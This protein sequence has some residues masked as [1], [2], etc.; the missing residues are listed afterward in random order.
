[1]SKEIFKPRGVGYC[2]QMSRTQVTLE[3]ARVQIFQVLQGK[4]IR[5]ASNYMDFIL[6]VRN[7]VIHKYL[8]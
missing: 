4:E 2:D 8:P 5:I 6:A 7:L 3:N 1:M